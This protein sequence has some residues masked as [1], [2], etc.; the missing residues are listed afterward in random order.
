M[1]NSEFRSLPQA[2]QRLVRLMQHINYGEIRHLA[3]RDGEP[4]L[5][6]LPAVVRAVKFGAENGARQESAQNDFVLKAQ[7][8]QLLEEIDRLPHGEIERIEIKGGL[9][10][11]ALIKG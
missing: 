8:V 10:F 6:P 5:D 7:V 9:P 1:N 3:I 11:M 4:V 2:R